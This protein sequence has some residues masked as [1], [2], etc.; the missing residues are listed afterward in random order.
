MKPREQ[1]RVDAITDDLREVRRALDFPAPGPS[2]NNQQEGQSG[3]EKVVEP[4]HPG[5]DEHMAGVLIIL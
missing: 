1:Q 5:K 4:E 3:E 2:D